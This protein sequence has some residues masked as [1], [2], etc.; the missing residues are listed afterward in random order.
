MVAP[1]VTA[2][3]PCKSIDVP[4]AHLPVGTAECCQDA[5]E[6]VL[7]IDPDIWGVVVWQL[8]LGGGTGRN[9]SG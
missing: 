1:Q 2:F 8:A 3:R 4:P 5:P 9:G 6:R 7:A